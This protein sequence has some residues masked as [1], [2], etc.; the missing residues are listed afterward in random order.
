MNRRELQG[1]FEGK[2]N[3]FKMIDSR[4]E[5][6]QRK[7]KEVGTMEADSLI[8]MNMGLA[9]FSCTQ[10]TATALLTEAIEVE[11]NYHRLMQER[12]HKAV[13]ALMGESDA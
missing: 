8:Q 12:F 13:G 6:L 11:R 2:L 3:E 4:I 9:M 10:E 5:T 7:L 1:F